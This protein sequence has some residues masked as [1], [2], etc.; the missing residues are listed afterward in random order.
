[1]FLILVMVC[2]SA[3][4]TLDRS[5]IPVPVASDGRNINEQQVV[6]YYG[7][8]ATT[9]SPGEIIGITY[10][11]YQTN[12]SSGNR[13]AVDS[14]GGIHV[15]W[16]NGT[17]EGG[18]PR[19]VYYN[20]R[21]ETS[22]AWILSEG[23]VVLEEDGTG[24]VTLDLLANGRALAAYHS[25]DA[26]GGAIPVLA[27]DIVRGFGI[28]E[29]FDLDAGYGFPYIARDIN[30]RIHMIC[31]DWPSTDNIT[32]TY[33]EDDG[34]SWDEYQIIAEYDYMSYTICSSPVSPR[35]AIVYTQDDPATD[36]TNV[37][38]FETLD[39]ENWNWG[40]PINITEFGDGDPY[41]AWVDLDAIY[42][43]ADSLHITYQGLYV[44]DDVMQ[45]SGDVMHWSKVAGH[46]VIAT[47]PED[48][49]PPV[50]C[51]CISKMSLG[52]DPSDNALYALWSEL[53]ME[54]VSATG[55]SNGE[56]YAASSVDGGAS[57]RGKVNLTNSPTPGCE[58][59]DCDSDVWSSMAEVVN[60][61]LRIMYID[62]N[63]AGA[64]WNSE[65]V[66]TLND[67]LYLD[68][69]ALLLATCDYIPGDCNHNGTALELGDV[70]A[71]IGMYR[72]SV[73]PLYEC[74]CPPHGYNFPATADPN[75]NCIANELID[76]VAEIQAYRGSGTVS[77]CVDCPGSGR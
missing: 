21:E 52:V 5:L 6:V 73:V 54:D 13:I 10:F 44:I 46:T 65:G 9:N 29:R 49:D 63:D 68:V 18:R 47:G 33:S 20:F 19:Y 35:T 55:F 75:G 22:G 41:S 57:W 1:M 24:F 72:G 66:W 45:I 15:A 64:A 74:S 2:F 53:S 7:P 60:D 39:G 51:A 25:A 12:G 59:P 40:D 43:Y 3:A 31:V 26:P 48:C 11:E 17:A 30:G 34:E 56:L 4:Q 8:P 14:Y 76:A 67:V 61:S 23:G 16:T 38:Y 36:Y 70:I 37:L 58:P 27:R 50:Y 69:P 28:W 71:M 62:D 32:Y 42:D 77:S